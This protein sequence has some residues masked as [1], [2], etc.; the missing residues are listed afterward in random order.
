M[1]KLVYSQLVMPELV[2]TR[3]MISQARL[4]EPKKQ[5]N[6]VRNLDKLWRNSCL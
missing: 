2:D 6:F 5:Q 1:F 4:A 3:L